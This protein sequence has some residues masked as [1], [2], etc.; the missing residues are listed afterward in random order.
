MPTKQPSWD[1]YEAVILLEGLIASLEG[2][3]SRP[4]AVKAVSQKLRKIALNRGIEIDDTYRNE[5]GISFQMKSMESAYYGHT[6]F[7]PASRLFMEVVELYHNSTNEYNSL[8]KEAKAMIEKS[9]SIEDEFIK[10]LAGK[11]SPTQ[12]S[13]FYLCYSEIE[14]FCLKV[15]VL[16]KPLFQTTDFNVIKNV[17]RTIEQ[18]KIFRLTHKKQ[19][20]K[21][22]AAGRHYYNFIKEKQP[23]SLHQLVPEPVPSDGI[24]A[25]TDEYSTPEVPPTEKVAEVPLVRTEQDQRLVQKY[26]IIYKRLFNALKDPVFEA[27]RGAGVIELCEKINRIARPSV[28]EEILDNVSWALANGEKYTFSVDVVDHHVVIDEPEV[29]VEILASDDASQTID[30]TKSF[31]L[32]YTKPIELRYFGDKIEFDNTWTSLYVNT[33]ATFIDDYSHIFQAGMSFSKNNGRVELAHNSDYGF[34]FA[35]KS[36]PRTE[37]M[38][39]TNISANDIASKIRFIM[40]LCNVDY[41]NVEISYSKKSSSGR[42]S[43]NKRTVDVNVPVKIKNVDSRSFSQYLKDTLKMAEATCRSYTS[44]INGCEVFAREHGLSSWRLY[45]T[46]KDEARETSRLL[47][48]NA[49][50]LEYNS[51]QHNR[52]RA[53]LQK[54]LSFI[55]SDIPTATPPVAN[56]E[57]VVAYRNEFYECVLKQHFKKGF[58]LESPLEIRKFRKYYAA[59]H[60]VELTDP[61]EDVSKIIMQLCIEYE[62][63]AFLPEVMLS[64][65]LKEKLFKYIDNAFAEGKTAIYYQAIFTEFEDVFLDYHIHD[66][67]MLKAYLNHVGNGRFFIHR[68]FVSKEA[69]VVLD[70]LSEIRSCLQGFGRPVEYDELFDALPHLPQN[71]I[72]FILATNGEFVNNGH[73]AYFHESIVRLSNE[74][75]EGISNIIQQTIDEKH[76]IGGNELYDA[77]KAKYPYIIDDNHALSVYGF[78][79]ALKA[80]LGDKFSFKGNIISHPG[81]ELSMADVFATFAKN[82][83][84]FTLAELQELANNLATAI[85][86]ESVY[87]NSLR[88]SRDQFVAKDSAHFSI[89]ETDEALD[90][91]CIGKYIPIQAVTNFGIFPYAGYPW[92]SFMLEHYVANY[93]QKYMILHSSFNGTE[94]AGAIV[95]RSAGISSFDDLIV[96]LLVN[97]SIEMKKGPVLQFLSDMGYLARRRYSKIE[98]LIIKANAQ[99]NRKD[100]D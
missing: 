13:E 75:L 89:F 88:I 81:Q 70:P 49:D 36:V 15:K 97:N 37:Y 83:D 78:R 24:P 71:N 35:P 26:P 58:R 53:A 40:D 2:D 93:S 100:K 99:R 64:E 62:G 25:K 80:K 54:F 33:V 18:N 17:Q 19:F 74:E 63:K 46:N 60:N 92:N 57:P 45:G 76:F 47:L 14:A 30:F 9:K 82:R 85:Y 5:N 6:I 10:Y 51:K 28:V 4:E 1:K 61:D 3:T 86:F 56:I 79:D 94:C 73:G 41:E 87:E 32:A 84:S 52:F 48:S 22:V 43:E 44:A 90:R 72:K 11:V 21:I 42:S 67:E 55:G 23:S 12:L 91:V 8:L 20:N 16:Q 96:D 59:T 65:D 98:A 66:A 7:K 39:E 31:D 69:N 34:M 27:T 38:L 77:I 68:S 50:F 95:K 29:V